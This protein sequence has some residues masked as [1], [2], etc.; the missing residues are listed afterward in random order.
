[1]K[2]E[3]K[4]KHEDREREKIQRNKNAKRKIYRDVR[5]CCGPEQKQEQVQQQKEQEQQKKQERQ[6]YRIIERGKEQCDAYIW[7]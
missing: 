1:M 7:Q 5:K 4:K 2:E 3:L 6:R